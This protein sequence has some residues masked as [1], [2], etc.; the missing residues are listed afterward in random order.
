MMAAQYDPNI[1]AEMARRLSDLQRQMLQALKDK[2]PGLVLEV[3]V[4]VLKFPEDV[5]GPLRDLQSMNLVSTQAV[6]GQ[7]GGELFSLT[8]LGEQVLR[9]LND[10]IF[11]LP[12]Q[13]LVA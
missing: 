7:F 4:R 5:V 3:A 12:P 8:A 10:P 9:L 1:L 2:G 13:N 11:Q 6:R